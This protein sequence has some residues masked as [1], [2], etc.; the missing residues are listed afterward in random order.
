[1]SGSAGW[2]LRIAVVDED[3]AACSRR[4]VAPAVA[5]EVAPGEVDAV[6]HADIA[7]GLDP[8]AHVASAAVPGTLAYRRVGMAARVKKEPRMTLRT[9]VASIAELSFGAM[10]MRAA[11]FA[12]FPQPKR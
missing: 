1:M 12:Y 7:A 4:D 5:D 11:M 6:L 2:S 3:G 8:T 10:A 9:R